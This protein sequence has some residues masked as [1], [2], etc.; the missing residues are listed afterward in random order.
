MEA[1]EKNNCMICFHILEDRLKIILEM[2]SINFWKSRFSEISYGD[3]VVG[4]S[5]KCG[6]RFSINRC[7]ECVFR[8]QRAK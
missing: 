2:N 4:M 6:F 3:S 5:K 8:N 1:K 7:R